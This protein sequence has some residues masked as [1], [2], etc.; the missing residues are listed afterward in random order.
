MTILLLEDR[1]SVSFGLQRLLEEDSHI[2]F[3][4]FNINDAISYWEDAAIE[5]LIVDLNISPDG[6]KLGEIEETLGGLLTGWIW[7]REYVYT[8]KEEFKSRTIIYSNYLSDL[9]GNV[10][11]DELKGLHL[12]P[13]SGIGSNVSDLLQKVKIINTQIR[14]NL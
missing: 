7:L 13:K 8:K 4:A 6:L 11:E 5:C 1:G 12:I 2:I 14:D 3:N 9:E 10:H